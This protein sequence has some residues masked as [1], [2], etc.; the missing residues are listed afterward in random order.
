MALGGSIGLP[1][2]KSRCRNLLGRLASSS[3][4]VLGAD[5]VG[6][7]V[8]VLGWDRV[9]RGGEWGL[10]HSFWPEF[11]SLIDRA[12]SVVQA[13]AILSSDRINLTAAT[14]RLDAWARR[15]ARLNS[16]TR[17]TVNDT[18]VVTTH[19]G[20][21]CDQR[22]IGSIQITLSKLYHCDQWNRGTLRST[23]TSA[24]PNLRI[25]YR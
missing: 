23:A 12:F 16:Y 1:S 5:G 6:R 10:P 8:F 14:I 2:P 17:Q 25:V 7:D 24:I 4:L 19:S 13:V 20:F 3:Q 11:L 22:L 9:P 15:V 21:D 18:L